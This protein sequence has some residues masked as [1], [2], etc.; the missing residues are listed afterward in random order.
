MRE[1]RI[2]TAGKMAGLPYEK[3]MAW[4]K[5]IERAICDRT[6]KRTVFI[7][8]PEFYSYDRTDFQSEKEVKDWELSQIMD[9]DVV[10]TN[11][12]GINTSVGTH[13][14]LSAV[15]SIN[16][17]SN[18]HIFIIGVGN[19][20]DTLHPWIELSLHRKEAS[21]DDAADYIVKYLLV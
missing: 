19:S 7:H 15:D 4:R 9:C 17:I 6:N 12:D 1:Y 14:E 5:E 2:Y 18:K 16:S 3:Q 10:V 11:L 8:P 21:I 13:F 20:K